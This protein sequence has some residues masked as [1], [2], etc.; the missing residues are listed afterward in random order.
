MNN[1][2]QTL[3]AIDPGLHG[4]IAILHPD[5]STTAHPMPL[6]GKELDLVTLAEQ[7]ETANPAWIVIEKVGSMPGQGVASTF[8]FGCGYGS[9]LGIAAALR[10]PVE[11]VT[12]QRWK[13]RVLHGTAKDKAS[14]IAFCRRA[15]PGVNLVPPRCRTPHDGIADA[16]CLLEY[17]RR[18]LIQLAS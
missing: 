10:V 11:L 3:I 14:A 6:A 18:E 15:Y 7:V 1:N 9:L 8:K 12:P 13:A 4:A 16:V 2:N 5:G 17:G